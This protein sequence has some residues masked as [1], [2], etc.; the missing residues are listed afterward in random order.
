MS[1][2]MIGKALSIEEQ[3]KANAQERRLYDMREKAIF[4]DATNLAA[5]EAKGEA[6]A[7]CKFLESRFGSESQ[8]LQETVR[9]ITDLDA[10]SRITDQIFVVAHLDEATALI[11]DYLVSQ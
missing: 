10:L 4:S 8:A 3:F 6:K 11:E 5:A 9:T 1:N 2:P 7:I